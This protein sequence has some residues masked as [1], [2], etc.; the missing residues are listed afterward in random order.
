[1]SVDE[2]TD[3]EAVFEDPETGLIPLIMQASSPGTLKQRAHVVIRKLHNRKNEK[4]VI[5][6]FTAALDKIIPDNALRNDLP[7]MQADVK[8]LLRQIKTTRQRRA[9]AFRVR[10]YTD[11]S[12]DRRGAGTTPLKKPFWKAR[13]TNQRAGATIAIVLALV[14]A[15]LMMAHD[16]TPSPL[17]EAQGRAAVRWVQNFVQRNLPMTSLRLGS[18]K[19]AE[20]SVIE[21]NI[22]VSKSRDVKFFNALK[23]QSQAARKDVLNVVC[24]AAN[25]GVSKFLD[26]G[27]TFRV[28]VR[29]QNAIFAAG[30]CQ[31]QRAR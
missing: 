12:R 10:Q 13:P 5:E 29:G 23:S 26:Q 27:W 16:P 28:V 2:T 19:I 3:W 1:M 24:P 20:N 22:T 15:G 6:A 18:V 17:R 25:S 11:G 31:Y 21:L 9:A 14:A 7:L 30:R 8:T 4:A